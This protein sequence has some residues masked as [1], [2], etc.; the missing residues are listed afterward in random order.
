M[1]VHKVLTGQCSVKEGE[2][3][4]KSEARGQRTR[5]EAD[6]LHLRQP[7]A[8][9]DIRKQFFTVRVIKQWN[10]LPYSVRAVNNARKFKMALRKYKTAPPSEAERS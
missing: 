7:F 5:A 8:R 2:W 3:F 1:L 4:Q 9:L 6:N 10:R